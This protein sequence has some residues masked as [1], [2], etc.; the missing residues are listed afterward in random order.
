ML[1][2]I[3]PLLAPTVATVPREPD[4]VAASSTMHEPLTRDDT[5]G[6]LVLIAGILTLLC[7]IGI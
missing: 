3:R 6:L 7:G 1:E 4:N 5:T 2:E